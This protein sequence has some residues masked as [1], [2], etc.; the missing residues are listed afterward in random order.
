MIDLQLPFPPTVNTYWRS[1]RKGKAAGRVVVSKKGREYRESAMGIIAAQHKAEPL[2]GRLSVSLV[3]CP[4]D[5]RRRD[6][7]NYCKAL[8]DAITHAQVWGDDEQIDRLSI[9]RGPVAMGGEVRAFI[10]EIPPEEIPVGDRLTE[11]EALAL[12]N[13]IV[14]RALEAYRGGIMDYGT[15]LESAL[16]AQAES[17]KELEKHYLELIRA[18][19]PH[20]IMPA[21]EEEPVT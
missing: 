21:S 5:R 10:E 12:D 15:A 4:P 8:L 16:L 18:Q 1:L 3:L 7:D 2:T 20:I 9:E 11:I 13:P 19:P 14:H 6:L 17:A